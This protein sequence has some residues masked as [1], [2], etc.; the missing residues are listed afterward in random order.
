MNKFLFY[1]LMFSISPL[2]FA[3]NTEQ[4]FKS[5]AYEYSI[6]PPPHWVNLS[7]YMKG[8]GNT[9][10]PVNYLL[11]DQQ[12]RFKTG[13]VSVYRRNVQQPL[14]TD[15]LEYSS[16]IE[17]MFNPAY[18]QLVW[19]EVSLTRG[20]Q[21]YN[22]LDPDAITL[23]QREEGLDNE[24][25]DGYVTAVVVISGS[26]KG[27]IVDYSYSI[28]GR[29]PI[30]DEHVFYSTDIGWGVKVAKVNRRLLF[31]K[32]SGT[33]YKNYLNSIEPV[34]SIV[35]GMTEYRWEIM[36]T[37]SV[38]FEKD[39]PTWF[40]LYP[41]ISFSNFNDWRAVSDWAVPL[42]Q[43]R[44]IQS[45]ELKA[46]LGEMALLTGKEKIKKA[47]SFVQG[48]IRYLGV[49]LGVNSHKPR[50]PDDVVTKRFG[51]CKDKT[52]LLI[53]ML[54][55]FGIKAYPALVS[56]Y[57][58]RNLPDELPSPSVF[59]H[60][61]TRVELDGQVYWLDP[62]RSL[63]FG[64]LER[65]G[66]YSYDNALIVGHP[67]L[68]LAKM[69]L[70]PK[71]LPSIHTV[72]HIN[73]LS[74]EAPV[75]YTITTEY[76][77]VEADYMRAQFSRNG[78]S[79]MARKFANY[80]VSLYPGLEQTG[81]LTFSDQQ[82]INKVTTKEFYRIEGFFER[83]PNTLVSNLFAYSISS[84]L[85]LPAT[86]KRKTPLNYVPP[87]RITHQTKIQ[88]P[89]YLNMS[90]TNTPESIEN[91][92][93][94]LSFTEDYRDFSIITTHEY[95][96]KNDYVSVEESSNHIKAL[97]EAKELVYRS[98]LTDYEEQNS[99]EQVLSHFI[100]KLNEKVDQ[101]SGEVL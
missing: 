83:E 43:Q 50:Q 14:S 6:S 5:N 86:I 36:N 91:D 24:I 61:I 62:T 74:Y 15:G 101:L 45:V 79:V 82:A 97:R 4:K 34:I 44:D 68:T 32:D 72:E 41:E 30:Y 99:S 85:T 56:T 25:V 35:D 23:I 80:M 67:T 19:H 48:E 58:G 70:A 16:K 49:E 95:E 22:K 7:D 87:I 17:V 47:L 27:D 90:L 21:K 75:D 18:Q 81:D 1:I 93:F 66:Y 71:I 65:L 59:N 55:P 96:A 60:V 11:S 52:L 54:E 20:S 29:N 39:N 33:K 69:P 57:G 100:Y 53:A 26:R 89:E 76:T 64:E 94:S 8:K 38:V 98:Y 37:P 92:N 73:I 2:S 84:Y 3:D 10:E 78:T 77:G 42:Y 31:E 12:V 9:G 88:F 13:D 40:K 46:V 28:E 51:D 63:Q